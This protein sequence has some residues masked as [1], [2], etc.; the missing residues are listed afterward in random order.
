LEIR[1]NVLG[2]NHPDTANSYNNIGLVYCYLSDYDKALEHYLKSLEIQ[3][4]VLGKN[5]P[6]IAHT[7]NNIGLLYFDKEDYERALEYLTKS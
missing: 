5:H 2:K 3:E 1:E 7:Y 6:N 4:N